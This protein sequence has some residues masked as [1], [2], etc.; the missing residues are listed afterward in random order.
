VICGKGDIFTYIHNSGSSSNI[1]HV[2]SNFTLASNIAVDS[3]H[4]FSNHFGLS[5]EISDLPNTRTNPLQFYYK[6]EREKVDKIL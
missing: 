3:E 4:M 1:D 5:F 6:K 2:V